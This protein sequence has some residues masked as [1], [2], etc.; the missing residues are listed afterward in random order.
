[1][2]EAT[3]LS[4]NGFLQK[5]DKRA[6][7]RDKTQWTHHPMFRYEWYP[8]KIQDEESLKNPIEGDHGDEG[9]KGKPGAVVISNNTIVGEGTK[10][11]SQNKCKIQDNYKTWCHLTCC[12]V[13]SSWN[14]SMMQYE[15][16]VWIL[17]PIT[18][19]LPAGLL[20][21]KLVNRWLLRRVKSTMTTIHTAASRSSKLRLLQ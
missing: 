19:F 15:Q 20:A 13:Y 4:D 9:H 5:V 18:V 14:E 11:D 6:D 16:C 10:D 21:I 12:K 17:S 2:V 1:M 8:L 7:D 3:N